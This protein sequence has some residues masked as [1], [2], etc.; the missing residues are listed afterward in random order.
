MDGNGQRHPDLPPQARFVFVRPSAP[1]G[2]RRLCRPSSDRALL[3]PQFSVKSILKVEAEPVVRSVP[4]VFR[5][6]NQ[7]HRSSNHHRAFAVLD[8]Y[9]SSGEGE[10]LPVIVTGAHSENFD[11]VLALKNNAYYTDHFQAF[12]R[13]RPHLMRNVFFAGPLRWGQYRHVLQGAEFFWHNVV[14]DNGTAGCFEAAQLGVPSLSSDYPQ[15]HYFD[16]QFGTNVRFF[17]AFDIKAGV[18]ALQAMTAAAKN[19]LRATYG[20][21]AATIGEQVGALVRCANRKTCR[22]GV[23]TVAAL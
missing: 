6:V 11:P 1:P 13:E 14:Y 9:Y 15:M 17:S 16:A 3:A 18:H 7:R 4:P 23:H 8:A 20:G 10:R 19:G 21:P 22:A 2:C 12:I 5:L